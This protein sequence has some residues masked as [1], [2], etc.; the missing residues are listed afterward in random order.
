MKKSQIFILIIVFTLLFVS[1]DAFALQLPP[2]F[3]DDVNDQPAAPISGGLYILISL[4]IGG[5]IGGK[6]LLKK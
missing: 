6:K 5:I 2:G 1:Q 4:I 3:E